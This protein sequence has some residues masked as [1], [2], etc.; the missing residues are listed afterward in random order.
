M[1]AMTANALRG[2]REKCLAS[3]MDDYLTKP[4]KPDDLDRLLRRWA[5]K[6]PDPTRPGRHPTV[7]ERERRRRGD[8]GRRLR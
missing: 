3:G 4:L 5:P 2:H 6:A 7:P 1:I 8:R